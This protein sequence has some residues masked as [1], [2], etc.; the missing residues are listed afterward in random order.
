MKESEY[1]LTGLGPEHSA[2]LESCRQAIISLDLADGVYPWTPEQWR[3][4][5]ERG[6][7]YVGGIQQD[8]ELLA[9]CLFLAN[10]C[11]GLAHLLKLVVKRPHR[12]QKRGKTLLLKTMD[13]LRQR[14]CRRFYLEV[15]TD[16]LPAQGLYR[17]LGFRQLHR[18]K[19]FY[20]DG[21]D[22]W[23]MESE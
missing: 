17:K 20:S 18:I 4:S 14:G 1:F 6:G 21:Q 7:Y 10:P 5:L 19:K 16:N 2:L 9:F 12:Q 23:A 3:Q 8:G 15:G 13:E 11:E 22:A